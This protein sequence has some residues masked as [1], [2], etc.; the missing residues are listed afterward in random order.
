MK[1]PI[2]QYVRIRTKRNNQYQI[3]TVKCYDAQ[4]YQRGDAIKL[5]KFP[6]KIET[7]APSTEEI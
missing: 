7:D 3:L 5:Q 2:N 4:G 1:E 6:K